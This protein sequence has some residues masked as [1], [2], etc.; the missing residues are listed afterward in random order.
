MISLKENLKN[1]RKYR[2]GIL[3]ECI[4]GGKISFS[5]SGGGKLIEFSLDWIG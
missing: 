5:Y 4:N 1:R 3:K 2:S